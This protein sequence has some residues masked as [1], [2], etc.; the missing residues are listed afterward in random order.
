MFNK[1]FERI[2]KNYTNVRDGIVNS[3]PF[4]SLPSLQRHVPGIMK[5]VV[6]QVLA[7]SGVGKTQLTKFLFVLEPYKYIKKY[8]EKG[9]KLKILYFALEESKEEFM[10]GLISNRMKEEFGLTITPLDL[11]S[12]TDY[13][14]NEDIL[15]KIDSC[16][17][18]FE[19]LS[20][21]IDVIDSIAHPFGIYSYVKDYS[22]KNGTHHE[23]TLT[24][25]GKDVK[26]YS[27]YTPNDDNEFVIVVVDH[28]ALLQPEKD[29]ETGMP[30]TLHQTMS[31]WSAVFARKQITKHFKYS[32]INVTQMAAEGEKQQYTNSGMAI[33]A[34]LEPSLANVGD[35]KLVSRDS[36]VV[37]GLMSPIRYGIKKQ[38]G[39]DV[40]KLGDNYRRL[41]IVKNRYGRPDLKKGLYFDGATNSFA[42]LPSPE[43]MDY[44]KYII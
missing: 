23:K 17:A 7:A 14:M 37:L 35:N 39:Y 31:K 22:E 21:S 34:K 8:P 32:V 2:R 5:G 1:T 36:G 12:Y 18:Y 26:V 38:L 41:S 24:I 16:R 6:Y 19:E 30:M 3:I 27:H 13:P 28:L 42:E 11:Q 15:S 33:E 25:R 9:I 40:E 43:E 29:R 20:E 44:S 4:E 10:L